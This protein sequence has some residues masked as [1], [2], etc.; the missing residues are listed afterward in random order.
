MIAKEDI[1]TIRRSDLFDPEWYLS[2]YPDV[3]A[4]GMDPAEHYLWVG[5]RLGRNPSPKF[6]AATYLKAHEDVAIQGGNPLLHHLSGQRK[7][8]RRSPANIP[9]VPFVRH[10]PP[11]LSREYEVVEKAFDHQFYFRKYYDIAQVRIDPVKHYI[12]HGGRE[13]RDPSPD[14]VTR[15]YVDRYPDV[16]ESGL[17]PFYHYLT[18]GKAEGRSATPLGAGH[19]DFDTICEILGRAP[20]AVEADVIERRRDLRERL[21]HGV[22]GEMITKAAELDP[23]IH[24][25]TLAGTAARIPPFLSDVSLSQVA[26]IYRLQKAAGWRRAR[27][28]VAIRS[29][30]VSGAAR[31]AG[32]LTTALA[33]IY[34][35]DEIVVLR[36]DARKSNH[37]TWFPAGCRDI[38]FAGIAEALPQYEKELL[39]V[40][41][42]RS[43]APDAAFNLNSKLF[44]DIMQPFGKALSA[45]MSLH[46]YLFCNDKTVYGE[47]DGYPARYFYRYFDTYKSTLV[48]SHFLAEDLREKFQIP[49]AQQH[50]LVAL[51]TPI[52][53][54]VPLAKAPPVSPDRRPQIFWAGRFDRQ[55]RVDIV[56][57]VAAQVPEADFRLWGKSDLDQDFQRLTLPPN[58]SVAGTYQSFSDL[59][60]SECD[61]WFYTS[62]WDGV[63]NVLLEVTP[64][65]IPLV[66]STAGGCTELLA[67]GLCERVDDIEDVGAFAAAIR[68][69]LAN[70][71][72]AREKARRLREHVL[73]RRAPDVYR[74]AVRQLLS[75]GVSP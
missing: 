15:Y 27:A 71:A 11:H 10:V 23:L 68:R 69:V 34:G 35:P 37:P 16:A 38:D 44:W 13:G 73:A 55:K 64:T 33:E 53:D 51:D 47:W 41:F 32:R 63:P 28:V 19:P 14:F 65:G 67:E 54:P 42:L 72:Q 1:E 9:K 57:A 56:V 59:P 20:K 39:F 17:N 4:L 31:L 48:D 36:T 52:N 7:P 60:L 46:A 61:M 8:V 6:D 66:S 75:E 45:S 40:E 62:E 25:S 58:L 22:L 3:K 2:Q 49:P 21:E 29:G 74:A 18:I 50:K 24:R 26:A 5:A 70:P 30:G 12:E 43:L